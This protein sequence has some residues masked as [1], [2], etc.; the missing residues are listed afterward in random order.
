MKSP[1]PIDPVRLRVSDVHV[2]PAY[3][4]E[5]KLVIDVR[6]EYEPWWTP[7]SQA[8]LLFEQINALTCLRNVVERGGIRSE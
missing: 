4:D 2:T 7:L 1:D 8:N 5:E 3:G 6:F